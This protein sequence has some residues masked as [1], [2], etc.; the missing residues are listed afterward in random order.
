MDPS[1]LNALAASF[2]LSALRQSDEQMLRIGRQSDASQIDNRG[3]TAAVFTA[4]AQADDP[5]TVADLNTAS[6]APTPQPFVVPNFVTP[7]GN[8]VGAAAS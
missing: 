4:L 5:E 7:T 2:A 3:M 8:M 6:H 1:V